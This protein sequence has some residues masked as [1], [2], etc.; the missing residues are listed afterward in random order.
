MKTYLKQRWMSLLGVL[1]VLL[2]MGGIL[3]Q[4]RSLFDREQV[5]KEIEIMKSILSTSLSYLERGAERHRGVSVHL[6]R[7]SRIEGFYLYGQGTSFMMRVPVRRVSMHN[8]EEVEEKI[9]DLKQKEI[10]AAALSRQVQLL[11]SRL[12]L[13]RTMGLNFVMPEV[14]IPPMPPM[15]PTPPMPP[16]PPEAPEP[17]ETTVAP[18]AQQEQDAEREEAA[19]AR[20]QW[21]DSIRE[22][23][24]RRQRR[25]SIRQ[26]EE[27]ARVYSEGVLAGWGQNDVTEE[28]ARRQLEELEQEVAEMKSQLQDEK[29][30]SERT[31]QKILDELVEVLATHGDGL[32][33][34][35]PGEYVNLILVGSGDEGLFWGDQSQGTTEVLSLKKEDIQR[36]KTGAISLDQL[37]SA[38]THYTY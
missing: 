34:L 3:A 32:T 2:G 19:E 21:R 35:Q 13:N 6:F 7:E 26:M 20:R 27:A 23:E 1:F 10:S 24:A 9:A 38:I 22:M 14:M 16:E 11:R 17:S 8:I 4:D 12:A 25:D 15:P 30:E 18:E 36:Y 33:H 31:R 5:E 28:E 29:S 37:K